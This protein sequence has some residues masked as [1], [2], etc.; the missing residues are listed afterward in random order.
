MCIELTFNISFKHHLTSIIQC[1]LEL[2]ENKKLGRNMT[3]ITYSSQGYPK[4]DR[5]FAYGLNIAIISRHQRK[6]NAQ[7]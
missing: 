7:K 3:H 1:I 5:K 6:S 2:P 4:G